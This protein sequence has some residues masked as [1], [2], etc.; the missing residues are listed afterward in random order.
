MC[1]LQSPRRLGWHSP[2]KENNERRINPNLLSFPPISPNLGQTHKNEI[3][4]EI[5][6]KTKICQIAKKKQE[7]VKSSIANRSTS[8]IKHQNIQIEKDAAIVPIISNYNKQNNIYSN[9]NSSSQTHNFTALCHDDINIENNIN[10]SCQQ[11]PKTKCFN[12]H[13]MPSNKR[14]TKNNNKNASSDNI[15]TNNI[16]I[17]YKTNED[18]ILFKKDFNKWS[19]N[20]YMNEHDNQNAMHWNRIN[21]NSQQPQLGNFVSS[22]SSPESAYSTGYSTDGTSPGNQ[23]I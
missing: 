17:C 2:T 18:Q 3:K 20:K 6:S 15:N 13:L 16:N 9:R 22:L 7:V 10:I 1:F 11:I 4:C 12:S 19:S 14:V 21:G 5:V 23:K 8:T